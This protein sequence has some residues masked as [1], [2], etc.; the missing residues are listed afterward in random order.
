MP[1]KHHPIPLSGGDSKPLAKEF[2]TTRLMI[3]MVR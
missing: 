2:G 1:P 3:V